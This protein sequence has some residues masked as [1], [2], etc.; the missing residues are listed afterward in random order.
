MIAPSVNVHAKHNVVH[1][2][3]KV[4]KDKE[5]KNKVRFS[6]NSQDVQGS[7]YVSKDS[8]LASNDTIS[9]EIS[10]YEEVS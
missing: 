4:T 5:T 7:I 1:G 9:L 6:V 10:E 2:K 3:K 8:E